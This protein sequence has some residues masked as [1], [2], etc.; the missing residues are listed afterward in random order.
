M[1]VLNVNVL[2]DPVLGGGTAE[3]TFQMS[4]ALVSSGVECSILTT[5]VGLTKHRIDA[6]KSVN[7]VALHSVFKRYFIVLFSIS[8]LKKLIENVDVVHLMGHWS[9]L[10]ILVFFVT[11]ITKTPYV[12]CPAGELSLFGR[13]KPIKK[14]FNTLIGNRIVKSASGY[15]AVTPDEISTYRLYGVK[16]ESVTVIPNGVNKISDEFNYDQF[17]VN[18][19]F[20]FK[21]PYILFMGRLN[22]I[23]GPDLLLEAFSLIAEDYPSYHLVFAG[24]DGGMLN[25]LKRYSEKKLLDSRVHFIGYVGGMDKQRVYQQ[26]DFL[27]IPSRSDAMSIVVLEAGVCG[28]PVLITETCGFN[29][30]A[31]I[32]GGVVVKPN[33]DDLKNG[34]QEML[35]QPDNLCSMGERLK[36]FVESHYTW[37]IISQRYLDLYT[38]ILINCR[39]SNSH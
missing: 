10:N 35:N 21:S 22:E 1:R 7:V 34:L 37:D 12:I 18:T 28:T 27:V 30:V 24:P 16:P 14:I 31:N 33:V 38:K 13:S 25:T 5:D 23:K 29:E 32:D 4:N 6:L 19:D 2:L 8:K 9:M 39:E 36:N 17:Q 11:R 20:D 26:A 15:I 3:R